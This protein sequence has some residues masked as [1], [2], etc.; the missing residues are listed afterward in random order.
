MQSTSR[1]FLIMMSLFKHHV[2]YLHKPCGGTALVSSSFLV[3]YFMVSSYLG[4]MTCSRA[5]THS[6]GLF[7]LVG[8]RKD[9]I[10]PPRPV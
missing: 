8:K 6:S 1:N 10:F 5:F 7:N 9:R 4:I 2:F 3:I